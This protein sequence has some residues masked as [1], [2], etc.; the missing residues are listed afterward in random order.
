MSLTAAAG[1]TVTPT[2]P[3]PPLNLPAVTA[4]YQRLQHPVLITMVTIPPLPLALLKGRQ[5][6]QH[7][8]AWIRQTQ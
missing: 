5:Q 3:P 8:L 6:Q 4:R 2:P 7:L 1:V